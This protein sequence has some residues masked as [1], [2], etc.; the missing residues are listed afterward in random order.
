[1]TWEIARMMARVPWPFPPE[2]AR[3]YTAARARQTRDDCA[4]TIVER[5]GC[6]EPV[7]VA[8]CH[9]PYGPSR[10]NPDLGFWIATDHAGRGYASEAARAVLGFAFEVL[11]HA[12]IDAG[13]FAD[14]AASARVLTRL[15]FQPTGRT[16]DWPCLA[17]GAPVPSPEYELTRERWLAA[18]SAA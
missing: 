2:A 14:N 15:G 12:V 6:G 8:V 11:G 10:G 7:G 17:R 5:G 16:L 3:A 18:R 9:A 1:M 13:H 4:F